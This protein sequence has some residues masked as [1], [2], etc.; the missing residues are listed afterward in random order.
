MET[1][2]VLIPNTD[3]PSHLKNFRPIS[4]CNMIYKVITKVLVNK[5]RSFLDE[6]ISPL[7]GSF[8]LGRG[9]TDNIIIALEALNYMHK[10]KGNKG[11]LAFKVDLEK[12]YDN[13]SSYFLET[14]S[15]DFGFP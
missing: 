11:S 7:L 13:M 5:L 8:I 15:G 3:Q 1:L 14:I 12:A 10:F 4:L 2:T 9:T 6:L